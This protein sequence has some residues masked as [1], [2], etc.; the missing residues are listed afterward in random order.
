M[1][2]KEK[3]RAYH[4]RFKAEN[5]EI[6]AMYKARVA[7][8]RRTN[9]H[10]RIKNCWSANLACTVR[11]YHYDFRHKPTRFGC[12]RGTLI[13]YLERQFKKG[14]TWDNYGEVWQIDHIRPCASYNFAEEGEV[15]DCFHYTNLQPLLKA[16]NHSKSCRWNGQHHRVYS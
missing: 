1:T 14:M 16:E 4:L 9:E 7:E 10:D 13:W 3:R 11:R 15:D 5:P 2:N 6:Y 8:K 12:T